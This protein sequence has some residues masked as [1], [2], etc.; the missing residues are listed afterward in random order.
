MTVEQVLLPMR[1]ILSISRL[2]IESHDCGQDLGNEKNDKTVVK[3]LMIV[4]VMLGASLTK[5][6]G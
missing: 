6:H 1:T 5:R 4:A 2:G 3:G